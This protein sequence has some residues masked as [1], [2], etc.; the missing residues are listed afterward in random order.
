MDRNETREIESQQ[1]RQLEQFRRKK[2]DPTV[3]FFWALLVTH[4]LVWTILPALTQPNVPSE[5]LELLSL[6][7]TPAWG[8]PEQ[9][10]MAV[11]LAGAACAISSPS[12]WPA[13]FLAQLCTAVC[14]WAAWKFGREFLHPWTALCAAIVLEGC[15]FYSLTSPTL[16]SLHISRAFWAIAIYSYY[17]AMTREKRRYWVATGLCLGFGMLSHY[18]TGLLVVTMFVFTLLN[19]RARR[20]LDSSWPFLGLA[21]MAFVFMPHGF[22]LMGNEFISVRASLDANADASKHIMYPLTFGFS[23]FLALIPMFIML[24]PLVAWFSLEESAGDDMDDNQQFARRLLLWVTVLPPCVMLMLSLVSGMSLDWLSGTPV[25]TFV[26]VLFLMWSQLEETR[27]AWRKVILRSAAASGAFAALLIVMNVMMPDIAQQPGSVHFPG[28]QLAWEV[29]KAW[30]QEYSTPLTVVGGEKA[31]AQNAS[32]YSKAHPA[33]YTDLDSLKSINMSDAQLQASGGVIVWNLDA[34]DAPS[35]ADLYARFPTI[36]VKPSV[37]LKWQTKAK[38]DPLHVGIAIVRVNDGSNP[39]GLSA[40]PSVGT[41]NVPPAST[42]L[43]LPNQ[44]QPNVTLGGKSQP[45]TPP[46]S[47]ASGRSG[48]QQ[49]SGQQ[50]LAKPAFQSPVIGSPTTAAQPS[51]AQPIGSQPS[52]TAPRFP[53]PSGQPQPKSQPA[54]MPS[55]YGSPG[56]SNPAP[57]QPELSDSDLVLPSF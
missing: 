35:D 33:V 4:V 38:I 24:V 6:G 21:C 1:S 16:T 51:F 37:E 19:D 44:Q 30:D 8:Y 25:W 50:L 11:W 40:A 32:W 47:N 13:Y 26:G 54:P 34:E 10:P 55:L 9:P 42:A 36:L 31:L 28:K 43:S 12:V 56:L 48:I 39:T 2:D 45:W 5:T 7:Q 49:T 52:A 20:C 41:D 18:S 29:E 3:W 57:A 17:R 22:W 46:A 14:L 23:Q 15:Y 27:H 53:Q